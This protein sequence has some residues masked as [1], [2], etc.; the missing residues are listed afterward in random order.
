L[1][2]GLGGSRGDGLVWSP[3]KGLHDTAAPGFPGAADRQ[4]RDAP[5]SAS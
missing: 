1:L 5:L 2:L 3:V 4:Q